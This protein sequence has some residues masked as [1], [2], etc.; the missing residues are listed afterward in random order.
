LVTFS[1]LK[2]SMDIVEENVS[3]EVFEMM[4]ISENEVESNY[5]DEYSCD[6]KD[7]KKL[8]RF[9]QEELS[10]LVRDLGLFKE[11]SEVLSSRLKEK[12]Y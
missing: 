7:S 4:K 2:D 8:K 9:T 3:M 6:D 12:I 5:T 11:L 1:T 10:D